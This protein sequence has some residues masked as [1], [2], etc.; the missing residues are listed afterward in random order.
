MIPLNQTYKFKSKVT[1]LQI[2]QIAYLVFL[3]FDKSEAFKA[4]VSPKIQREF[5]LGKINTLC[6][7]EQNKYL[8][9]R[10]KQLAK[11]ERDSCKKPSRPS[12]RK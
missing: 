2:E 3:G 12:S 10:I 11:Y 8:L 5:S 6:L 4:V 7:L 9:R 1:K